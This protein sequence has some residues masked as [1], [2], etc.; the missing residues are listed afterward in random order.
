MTERFP[1]INFKVRFIGSPSLSVI[2]KI[3]KIGLEKYLEFIPTVSHERSIEFLM[4][5][6]ILLLVIPE[7]K[8][9]KGILTGKLFEY[10]AA[11]KPIICIGPS[12]G[13]AAE[14]IRECNAGKAF[15]RIM[16]NQLTEYFDEL[17]RRWK[18]NKNLNLTDNFYKKYSRLN[19]T[20]ELSRIILDI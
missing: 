16:E 2:N 8:D 1:E 15:D 5:S 20:A 12:D 4:Q 18:L 10:L 9:D 17:V 11:R 13:D 3:K 7:V 14:I 6:T 19:Q